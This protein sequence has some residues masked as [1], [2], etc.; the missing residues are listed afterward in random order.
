MSKLTNWLI[1]IG[2]PKE[3]L[4]YG[5]SIINNWK[6]EAAKLLPTPEALVA[7]IKGQA[8]F[9]QV[10]RRLTPQEQTGVDKA[11]LAIATAALVKVRKE[12]G[13]P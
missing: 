6:V 4:D 8:A 9:K 10:Y 11:L 7:S 2:V 3:L 1:K 5:Q 12:L 13:L